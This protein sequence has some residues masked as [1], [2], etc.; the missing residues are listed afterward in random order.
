MTNAQHA[1]VGAALLC[2]TGLAGAQTMYRCGNTFSQKPC[3]D[4]ATTVKVP[5][6]AAP[7]EASAPAPAQASGGAG[8]ACSSAA[9]SAASR[10]DGS[11][12]RVEGIR[13]AGTGVVQYAG[14]AVAG[15][16][17]VVQLA[18]VSPTGMPLGQV[19]LTCYLSEDDR[20]VLRI[21]ESD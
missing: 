12:L 8:Q 15:R 21:T 14:Q 18:A 5:A 1:L 9:I 6:N 7:S 11:K 3:G 13:P 19:A 17:Y 4:S 16:K 2:A 20:R 10:N